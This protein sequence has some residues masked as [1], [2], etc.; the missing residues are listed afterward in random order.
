MY[1]RLPKVRCHQPRRAAPPSSFGSPC[2][3]WR[4]ALGCGLRP[5]LGSPAR[6]AW[7]RA[8]APERPARPGRQSRR[9]SFRRRRLGHCE[10]GLALRGLLASVAASGFGLCRSCGLGDRRLLVDRPLDHRRAVRLDLPCAFA[11]RLLVHGGAGGVRL[12]LFARLLRGTSR[13]IRRHRVRACSLR[14]LRGSNCSSAAFA[15]AAAA[16]TPPPARDGG[17][18][19][20][21]RRFA[22]RTFGVSS[23]SS[24]SSGFRAISSSSSSS[25]GAASMRGAAIGRAAR[26]LDAHAGAFEA[27]VDHDLDRHSIAMLDV[28][29][30]GALL[31]EHVDRRVPSRRA[32]RSFRRGRAPPHPR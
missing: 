25:I 21:L 18:G 31:V 20:R 28:G 8:C 6:P 24:S 26:A 11:A 16:A 7:P 17:P 13:R 1:R 4:P 22:S 30:L 27:L 2:R 15:P 3:Y 19:G 10:L 5:R 14:R 23:S 29:E 12:R 32:G 9:A